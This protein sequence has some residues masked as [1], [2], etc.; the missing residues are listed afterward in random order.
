MEQRAAIKVCVKLME[1]ASKIFEMLKSA[2]S[3][4]CLSRRSV[5]E[6][7]KRLK[8]GH[9][10]LQDVELKGYPQTSR[11]EESDEV[12]QKS[13]AKDQTLSLQMSKE[14]TGINREMV[15][16]ILVKDLKK[17]SLFHIC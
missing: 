6:W 2:Y 15:Y 17:E 8:E 9:E 3:D 11:T 16:R 10:L 1:K 12:I 4:K 13:L 5:F 7:H 14:M